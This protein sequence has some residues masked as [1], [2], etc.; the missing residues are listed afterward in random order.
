MKKVIGLIKKRADMS[1]EEFRT[2][3]E[4]RHAPLAM[5][6][7]GNELFRDYRQN[8]AESVTALEAADP[9]IPLVDGYDCVTEIWFDDGDY[10]R[11]QAL[12]ANRP[13]I[14][15]ALEEDERNF[16]DRSQVQVMVC[17]EVLQFPH[18]EEK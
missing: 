6:L 18:R 4:T 2:Y 5:R 7:F 17:D 1:A 11:F 13:D 9:S 8:F 16:I 12:L 10:E 15:N 3:Y 14:A